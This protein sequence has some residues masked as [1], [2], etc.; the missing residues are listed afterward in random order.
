M[1]LLQQRP[2]SV[3]IRC[4]APLRR[5]ALEE[6]A[7]LA[8]SFVAVASK[9]GFSLDWRAQA[10]R[11]TLSEAALR[12]GCYLPDSAQQLLEAVQAFG[13]VI[14]REPASAS[15]PVA[16][17]WTDWWSA[18]PLSTEKSFDLVLELL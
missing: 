4:V 2:S 14:E 12:D 6:A 5:D 17:E 16:P 9:P 10:L 11:L 7:R 8:L 13:V 1:N 15:E 18:L 3:D